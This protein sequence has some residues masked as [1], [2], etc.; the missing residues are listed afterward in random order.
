VSVKYLLPCRCGRQIVVET[1][2]AGQTS[3]C[4][5]GQSLPIPTM[6]E[7]TRLE[8]A[9][10]ETGGPSE[11]M[12]GWQHRLILLGVTLLAM[13]FVGGFLLHRF[14]PIAPID[15]I[16]PHAV[17]QS[18]NRLS[19]LQTWHYWQLMKQGLD[20]HVDQRYAER[21]SLY[22]TGQGAVAVVALAGIALIVC[23]KVIDN[24]KRRAPNKAGE[25]PRPAA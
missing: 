17:Q 23:G 21:M 12:W 1:R 8:P 22:N 4:P 19:P 25:G 14:R 6:L 13:A 18:A 9:P 5:C 10:I 15:A 20:R 3:V 11:S 16:D 24:K 2:E 7:I